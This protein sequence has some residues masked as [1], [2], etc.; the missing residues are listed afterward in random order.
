MG[1]VPKSYDYC[2]LPLA[3]SRWRT[4]RLRA[5]S[6]CLPDALVTFFTSGEMS[7]CMAVACS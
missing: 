3:S 5:E 4:L 7:V 6:R 2:V 1:A